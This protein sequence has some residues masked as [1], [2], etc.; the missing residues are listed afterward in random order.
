MDPS[1]YDISTVYIYYPHVCAY[2]HRTPSIN[3]HLA[4]SVH[5]DLWF[6]ALWLRL[7]HTE[8][9]NH[10]H[11]KRICRVPHGNTPSPARQSLV[12][13]KKYQCIFICCLWPHL[14]RGA[15][16]GGQGGSDPMCL[17]CVP[18]LCLVDRL[19]HLLLFLNST[20]RCTYII[21]CNP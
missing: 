18:C 17:A 21:Y 8:L 19:Q 20:H 15:T 4:P 11:G 12:A 16:S 5:L 2:L 6:L 3:H 7:P 1:H 10:I 13:E 9:T 14:T